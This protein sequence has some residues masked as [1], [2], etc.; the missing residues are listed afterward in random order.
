MLSRFIRCKIQPAFLLLLL[1]VYAYVHV[2]VYVWGHTSGLGV[3]LGSGLGLGIG[4]ELGLGLELGKG[5]T[6][7]W[8]YAYACVRMYVRACVCVHVCVCVYVCMVVRSMHLLKWAGR[9]HGHGSG[10]YGGGKRTCW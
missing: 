9:A 3:G 2:C 5:L 4:L 6:V 8:A 7:G 1:D 10:G